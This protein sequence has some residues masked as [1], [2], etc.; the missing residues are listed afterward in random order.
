MINKVFNF[1]SYI[2]YNLAHTYYI[3]LAGRLLY[4]C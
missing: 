3:D 1:I 2:S 4:Y